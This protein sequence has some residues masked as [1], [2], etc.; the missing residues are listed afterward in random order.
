MTTFRISS[1][2]AGHV[3]CTIFAAEEWQH[4]F[5][6]KRRTRT[7]S[8][9]CDLKETFEASRFVASNEKIEFW[10]L[11][12]TRHA[13]LTKEQWKNNMKTRNAILVFSFFA[14]FRARPGQMMKEIF[15]TKN[16]KLNFILFRFGQKSKNFSLVKSIF[17]FWVNHKGFA[18]TYFTLRLW[19][20][21]SK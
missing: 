14:F 16:K 11:S 21:K 12:L 5:F 13:G 9:N 8:L 10:R 19:V 1:P 18:G 3:S 17:N 2:F 7:V 6:P 4:S 20:F 15:V